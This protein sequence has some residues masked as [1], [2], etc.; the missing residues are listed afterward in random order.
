MR[1]IKSLYLTIFLFIAINIFSQGLEPTLKISNINGYPVPFQNSIPYPDIQRQSFREIINLISWKKKRQTLNHSYSIAKRDTTGIANIETESGGRYQISYND[2]DWAIISIP[3]VENIMCTYEST[4]GPENYQDGVWYR[5]YFTVNSSWQGKRYVTLVFLGINYITD[6]WLN[7]NYIG[8]HEGGYTPFI[9]DITDFLDYTGTN[10]LAIRVDNIP[11]ESTEAYNNAILPYKKCDWFNYTGILRDVYIVAQNRINIVRADIKTRDNSG[12]FDV[13]MVFYN[14][15]TEK[16]LAMIKLEIFRADF[17]GNKITN[18]IIDNEIVSGPAIVA[19]NFNLA[20]Y[21]NSI[22]FYR[23]NITIPAAEY[24]F[25]SEPSLYILRLT[26][27]TNGV[28]ADRYYTQFGLRT[29]RSESARIIVNGVLTPFLVGVGRHEDSADE[30]AAVRPI[31]IFNDLYIIKNNL[32][33]NLIRTGHYPNHPITYKYADRLGLV[34]YCEIPVVWFDGTEFDIQRTQRYISKQ[35]WREMIY[36]NYNSPSIWFWGT[37]N[38]GGSGT[39]RADFISDLYNDAYSIDGTRLIL[40]AAAGSDLAD[41]T[42][43]TCDMIGINMY[44]GI[45]YGEVG[46]YYNQTRDAIIE[47]NSNFPNKPVL[48]TEFGNWSNPDNSR[49]AEQELTFTE[50]FKAFKEFAVRTIDGLINSNGFIIGCIWW[51]AFNWYTPITGLQTMGAIHMDRTTFKPVAYKIA[52]EY[53]NYTYIPPD[54]IFQDNLNKVIVYPNPWVEGESSVDYITF[55]YLTKNSIVRIY[56]VAE[57]L[58]KEFDRENEYG[59]IR[60]KLDDYTGRRVKPGIYIYYIIDES[61][62]I[63]KSGK[64]VIIK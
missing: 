39:Q 60:W 15:K 31:E 2:S 21:S 28:I 52:D 44:Y 48:I 20:L 35:I 18:T 34:S 27:Y 45:F 32:N 59:F 47:L 29:I 42:H 33:C 63:G 36:C 55:K 8:Y 62:N 10:V 14:Y 51:N 23:E 9:F 17:S 58:I 57:S 41:S 53:R 64:I 37:L 22:I 3:S 43:S 12:N 19:R 54:Y 50:T 40:Q 56:N 38:E 46:D 61:L 24:W 7:G 6:V 5:K 1:Q 30:G 25:P 13:N 26:L 4:S 11:W 49:V 16:S